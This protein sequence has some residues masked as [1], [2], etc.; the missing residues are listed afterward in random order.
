MCVWFG[1]FSLCVCLCVCLLFG[2]GEEKLIGKLINLGD[3]LSGG[4]EGAD[5]FLGWGVGGGGYF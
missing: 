1:D 5:S 3:G 4:G 2:L